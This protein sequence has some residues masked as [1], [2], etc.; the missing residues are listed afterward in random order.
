MVDKKQ[1]LFFALWPEETVRAQLAAALPPETL[2][3][4]PVRRDNIHLTLVF[5]GA[6]EAAM[7]A[8]AQ[9]AA[10]GVVCPP[11][12]LEFDVAGYFPRPQV[13]WVAP[14][15]PPMALA[16]LVQALREALVPCGLALDPR[17][18]R[19]HLT[20]ARKVR[21]RPMLPPITPIAWPVR[22]FSLVE[23]QSQPGGVSYLLL[24]SW[25]LRQ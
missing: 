12:D 20:L 2:D 15:R 18:Y 16:A 5:L 23:S 25:E 19:P 22:G 9:R 24:Q 21:R 3:G 14:A 1:R 10:S 11:F 7:R 17:S 6:V 13:I 8:C 4:R